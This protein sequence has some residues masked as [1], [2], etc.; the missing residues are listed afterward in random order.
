MCSLWNFPV[1]LAMRKLE[2][3]GYPQW[4]LKKWRPHDRGIGHFDT[5]PDCDRR[6]D[7]RTDGRNLSQLC[8]RA[9]K[10][11]LTARSWRSWAAGCDDACCCCCWDDSI[12]CCITNWCICAFCS[13]IIS[14]TSAHQTVHCSCLYFVPTLVMKMQIHQSSSWQT[15]SCANVMALVV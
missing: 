10:T 1:K 13:I 14:I 8:W 3:W 11:V 4:R 2:S 5:I 6:T 7:R 12:I 15:L 9:V